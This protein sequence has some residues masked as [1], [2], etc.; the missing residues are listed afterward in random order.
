M[1]RIIVVGGQGSGKTRLSL[2]LGRKLDLPVIHLDVLYWRAGWRPSDKTEF[3][4][5]VATA[6]AGD[7]WIVD[8]LV[9]LCGYIPV[10]V[11]SLMRSLQM[12][13]VQF[14]ALSMVLGV[15]ILLA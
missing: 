7:R 10:A 1:Q 8:G 3:R 2:A 13:L 14:Y 15:L 11:G 6:I 9:N 12:G 4:E 5:R